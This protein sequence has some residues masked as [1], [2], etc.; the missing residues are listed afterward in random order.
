MLLRPRAVRIVGRP[1]P[2][3]LDLGVRARALQ[4]RPFLRGRPQRHLPPDSDRPHRWANC[5]HPY[6]SFGTAAPPNRR[7]RRR[8]LRHRHDRLDVRRHRRGEVV[9]DAVRRPASDLDVELPRLAGHLSRLA[10]VDR[11]PERLPVAS[12]SRLHGRQDLD[13]LGDQRDVGRRR[14]RLPGVRVFRADPRHRRRLAHRRAEDRRPARRR[15]PARSG[16][17]QRLHVPRTSSMPR[18]PSILRRS[19]SSTSRPA[20]CPRPVSRRSRSAPAAACSRRPR[21]HRSRRRSAMRSR[22]R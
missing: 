2:R 11:R 12:R 16:A 17:G 19:T 10:A 22:A 14:R 15:A 18:S 8:R 5:L 9:R 3:S 1:E 4:R 20:A 7:R 6:G 21:P 13:R